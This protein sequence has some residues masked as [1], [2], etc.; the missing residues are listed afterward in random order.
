M[1]NRCYR[2]G[3]EGALVGRGPAGMFCM[4]V[5]DPENSRETNCNAVLPTWLLDFVP[6]ITWVWMNND[7]TTEMRCDWCEPPHY[8]IMPFH[9]IWAPDAQISEPS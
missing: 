6:P 2:C 1:G 9:W 5:N 3:H 8:R 4:N 7:R